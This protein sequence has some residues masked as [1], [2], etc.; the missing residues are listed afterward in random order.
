MSLYSTRQVAAMLEIRPDAL[1]RAIWVNRIH[2]PQK[3]PSGDF[4]WT[5]A[6]IQHASWVLLHRAYEPLPVGVSRLGDAVRNVLADLDKRT[7]GLDSRGG[8]D[9]R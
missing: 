1:S 6:D 5:D 3:S 4:L 8:D 9:G 2:S 7:T